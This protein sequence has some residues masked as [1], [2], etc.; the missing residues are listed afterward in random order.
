MSP[1]TEAPFSLA[2]T[3]SKAGTDVRESDRIRD[4]DVDRATLD[5]QDR[6][7]CLVKPLEPNTQF[8]LRVVSYK[9]PRTRFA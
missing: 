5:Q 1:T 4:V 9:S 7:W 8:P 3:L 2:K 6:A